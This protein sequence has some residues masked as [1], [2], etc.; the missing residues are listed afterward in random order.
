MPMY[1]TLM[2]HIQKVLS[3]FSKT[4]HTGNRSDLWLVILW[5]FGNISSISVHIYLHSTSI[6]K[7]KTCI[8]KI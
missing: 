4:K 2:S 6:Y 7:H 1:N 3:L 5:T 8:L